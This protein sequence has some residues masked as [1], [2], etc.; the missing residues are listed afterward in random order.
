MSYFEVQRQSRLPVAETWRRLTD[1]Q[2]HSD[3]IPLTA[4]SV[5]GQGLGAVF[6]ARTSVG[7]VGFDDPME[8]VGWDPPRSPDSGGTHAFGAGWCRIEKR[9]RVMVGWAELSVE[10]A[11]DGSLVTWREDVAVR[12][13]DRWLGLPTRVMSAQVF[14]RLVDGLLRP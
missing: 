6:T 14:G 4:V 2:S 5:D 10:P 7:P 8:V 1:W 9:G 13:T 12:G 11:G 3:H